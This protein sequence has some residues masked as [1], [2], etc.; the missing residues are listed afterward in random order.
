MPSAKHNKLRT[1]MGTKYLMLIGIISYNKAL[2]SCM[3]S[4][5]GQTAA[6]NGLKFFQETQR[7]K[8]L[9]FLIQ[10]ATPVTSGY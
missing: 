10:R 4:I 2:R 3:L 7:L 1:L 6:P 8:N 5:A 9:F